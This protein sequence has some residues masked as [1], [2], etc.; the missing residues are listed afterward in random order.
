[1]VGGDIIFA[2]YFECQSEE[3]HQVAG[4]LMGI[5]MSLEK[6]KVKSLSPG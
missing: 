2:Q 5:A 3:I 4:K 6:V 1:M